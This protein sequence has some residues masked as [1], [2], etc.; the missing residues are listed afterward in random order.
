MICSL[1]FESWS[2]TGSDACQL[3][4]LCIHVYAIQNQKRNIDSYHSTETV[5]KLYLLNRIVNLW[6]LNSKNDIYYDWF[7]Q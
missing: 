7:K 1:E 3:R 4:F 5:L 2:I 6:V